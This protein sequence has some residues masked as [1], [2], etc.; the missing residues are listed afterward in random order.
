VY[1]PQKNITTSKKNITMFESD[2]SECAVTQQ[3]PGEEEQND[4]VPGLSLICREKE[5][6]S[7]NI[8]DREHRDEARNPRQSFFPLY[9][10]VTVTIPSDQLGSSLDS[11][12]HLFLI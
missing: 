8:S 4:N 3:C 11:M 10:L 6:G 2:G 1:L 5:M 12:S 7:R 9:I